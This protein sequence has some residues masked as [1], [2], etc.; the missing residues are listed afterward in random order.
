MSPFSGA[1][2]VES[3]SPQSRGQGPAYG[4]RAI[5][6]YT[7]LVAT[8][9][10]VAYRAGKAD[11]AQA[12]L[13]MTPPLPLA[14]HQA[15]AAPV[16]SVKEILTGM[17]PARS[18]LGKG[19]TL[20]AQPDGQGEDDVLSKYNAC[21]TYCCRRDAISTAVGAAALMLG[22]PALAAPKAAVMAGDDV[23]QLKFVPAEVKICT[24]DT[25][26]WTSGKAGP[27]NVVFDEGAVPAGVDAEDI[28]K[29]EYFNNEGGTCKNSRARSHAVVRKILPPLSPARAS[30]M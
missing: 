7:A 27:H 4:A 10:I 26:A 8:V 23:G 30:C 25:V 17:Q 28:S 24:G 14:P 16:V 21:K 18:R 29:P 19:P 2:E 13:F 1:I 5:C 3:Q 22:T 20:Y 6:G 9:A 11:P 15:S 12:R